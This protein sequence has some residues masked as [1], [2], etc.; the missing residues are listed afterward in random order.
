MIAQMPEGFLKHYAAGNYY[1]S[2]LT[3]HPAPLPLPIQV[4]GAALV[5]WYL[6]ALAP[7]R[8]R[9]GTSLTDCFN[10]F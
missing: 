10:G 3:A 2:L 4:H 7:C 5:S 6:E 1:G 9:K 8:N